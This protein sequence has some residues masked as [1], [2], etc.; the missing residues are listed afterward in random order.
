MPDS[1]HC[2]HLGWGIDLA[3]SGLVLMAKCGCFEG[4]FMQNKLQTAYKKFTRWQKDYWYWL[5]VYYQARH[6][7]ATQCHNL[8]FI[9]FAFLGD[10]ELFV[11]KAHT[12]A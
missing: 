9:V 5:V 7:I 8:A 10:V 1:C 3:A 6:E 4:R 11:I 2:F 12:H